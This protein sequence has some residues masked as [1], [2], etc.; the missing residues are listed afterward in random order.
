MG[1]TPNKQTRRFCEA[2]VAPKVRYGVLL[3][4]PPHDRTRVNQNQG[5]QRE[6]GGVRDFGEPRVA[7]CNYLGVTEGRVC[8]TMLPTAFDTKNV[9]SWVTAFLD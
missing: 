1:D 3:A 2:K 7:V 6:A 4:S 5:A 9:D 8:L